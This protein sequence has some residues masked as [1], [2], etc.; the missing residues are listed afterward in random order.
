MYAHFLISISSENVRG[1]PLI[2]R[3]MFAA[4]EIFMLYS[5]GF[6]EEVLE[7]IEIEASCTACDK[8][9]LAVLLGKVC[10]CEVQLSID[11]QKAT[12]S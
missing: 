7:D 4:K 1:Q 11:L 10:D 8:M 9:S 12:K 2:A 5:Q 3:D 6:L